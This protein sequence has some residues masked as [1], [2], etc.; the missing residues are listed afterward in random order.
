MKD[1]SEEPDSLRVAV[2]RAVVAMKPETVAALREGREPFE[3]AL[4]TAEVAAAL[5]AKR[6]SEIVPLTHPV[7]VHYWKV[8]F[9][10]GE[11]R[12]E[13]T[14]TVKAFY[15]IGPEGEAMTAAA[16]AALSLFHQIS[17]YDPTFDVAGVHLLER[18]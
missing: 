17:H 6:T 3:G 7:P 1:I 8:E 5:A 10:F 4:K 11:G 9:E 2:A 14:V 18:P 13:I 15:R 16:V 12:L